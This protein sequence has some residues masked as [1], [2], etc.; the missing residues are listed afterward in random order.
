M[1]NKDLLKAFGYIDDKYLIEDN[2]I[3]EN[4]RISFNKMVSIMQRLKIE[5]T[6]IP[7]C[8]IFIT[9]L[10]FNLR[11]H[12]NPIDTNEKNKQW[13]LKEVSTDLRQ[14]SSI[15]VE[16][17]WNEKSINKQYNDTH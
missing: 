14:N 6:L 11:K 7:I 13:I 17:H 16:Q 10:G 15:D 4:N 5:Y 8:I 1:N 9:I 12:T 3:K 2:V